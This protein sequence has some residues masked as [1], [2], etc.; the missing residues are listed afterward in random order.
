MN[1]TSK[2]VGLT[3]GLVVGKRI[4]SGS[5]ANRRAGAKDALSHHGYTGASSG[6]LRLDYG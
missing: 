1:W 5:A 2:I 4:R 6:H 3:V